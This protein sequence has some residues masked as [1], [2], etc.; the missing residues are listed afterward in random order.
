MPSE[1]SK[2][3]KAE[4]GEV[5]DKKGSGS[6]RVIKATNA[7]AKPQPKPSKVKKEEAEEDD[8]RKPI[9]ASSGS[10]PKAAKVKKEE[11]DEDD[12]KPL[13]QRNSNIKLDKVPLLA[14]P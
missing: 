12:D 8:S 13:A 7:N 11:N 2:P 14:S 10:R 6:K 5:K 9:K 4:I 1:D 3:V